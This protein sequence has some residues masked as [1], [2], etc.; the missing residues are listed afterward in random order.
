M[1]DGGKTYRQRDILTPYHLLNIAGYVRARGVEVEIFDGEVDLLGQEE[2]AKAIVHWKPRF[3]GLTTTTPDIIQTLEVCRFI[4]EA[5]PSVIT[6][7]GGSHAIVLPHEVSQDK[8]VD[9]VVVGD[10]EEALVQII[11][12]ERGRRFR[13]ANK[14]HPSLADKVVQG[15][16]ID[17]K[18][19]PMPAHD[20]LNYANYQ[21]TDPTRGQYR[22]ATVMS[23]RGCPFGCNF[24]FH[25][26]HMRYRTVDS[27][28]DEIVFLYREKGVRYFFVYDDTFLLKRQRAMEIIQKI[29]ALGLHDANFQCQTR[30]NL[31]TPE[32]IEALRDVNFVRVS[33]GVESGSTKI[34][35]HI[36]KGVTKKDYLRACQVIIDHGIEARASFIIGHPYETH[37]TVAETI[38]FAKELN[39]L[40]ANFTVMTPYPGTVV[41]DMALRGEGIRF[42]RPEYAHDWRVYRRWGDPII[43]TEGLSADE[44]KRARERAV[45]EFYVQPKVFNYYR[46]LFEGGNRSRYFY[47]PLNFAWQQKFGT[48]IPFWSE[49]SEVEVMNP[50]ER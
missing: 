38:S 43:E 35:K 32:V 7:V 23:S 31:V 49:L 12:K 20:L 3:V 48:N 17:L 9:Y 13:I 22:T 11:E 24:C 18:T 44:L 25:T 6:I 5:M 37:Q 50:V 15:P 19:Q 21:F 30:G 26:R 1:Y 39:L 4:K 40:E 8:S 14:A 2:L 33:M 16:R 36:Q 47:R 10:G 42:V 29:K 46:S 45:T 28:V 34:L 41:Y 27:F